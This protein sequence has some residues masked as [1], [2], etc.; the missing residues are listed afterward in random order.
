MNEN[1]GVVLE[2]DAV[3]ATVPDELHRRSCGS[4]QMASF[5][6]LGLSPLCESFVSAD[7]LNAM[8]SFYPLHAYICKRLPLDS[9]R[10]VRDSS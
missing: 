10:S 8:E 3:G 4:A 2:D 9:A 1:V 5:I 6:D 7:R